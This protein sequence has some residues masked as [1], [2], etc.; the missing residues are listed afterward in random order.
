MR[1]EQSRAPFTLRCETFAGYWTLGLLR[2]TRM[3]RES[4]RGVV[5]G[6][7]ISLVRAHIERHAVKR[8]AGLARFGDYFMAT[9]RQT[10]LEGSSPRK[11]AAEFPIDSDG[12]GK[13][14]ADGGRSFDNKMPGRGRRALRDGD[15]QHEDEAER[16]YSFHSGAIVRRDGPAR[17]TTNVQW[18]REE[19]L[20][21]ERRDAGHPR[22]RR[23]RHLCPA[24]Q[25]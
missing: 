12:D 14:P 7:G 10:G 24:D 8:T 20:V 25:R 9:G 1:N 2:P 4:M 15:E 21:K 23:E 3:Q 18:L 19:V 16:Y 6:V 13:V 22:F 17:N 5:S 11:Q